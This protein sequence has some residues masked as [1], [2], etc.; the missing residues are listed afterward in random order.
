[1]TDLPLSIRDAADA[2]R[3]GSLKSVDL[4]RAS[5]ER[6]DLVDKELGVYIT[7]M[8]ETAVEAAAKADADFAAGIDRGPLQGIALAVKDIIATDDAPT[9]AQSLVL[10]PTWGDQG[11]APVVARLRAAGAVI[12][13]KTSTMEFANGLPDPEKPF[14]IP[15]NPWNPL[16]WTG[17]SSSGTGNGIAAGVFLGGLGTDTGGSIRIPSSWCGVTGIKATYGRVPKSGC[18]YNGY[19]LDYIGPM[20]RSA[21]DCAALLQVLAGYDASDPTCA[22]VPV[23]DYLAGM[24]GSVA[25]MRLGVEREH[26]TRAE[27]VNPRVAELFED[28][29]AALAG[30][31]AEIVEFSV[32]RYDLYRTAQSVMS[33]TEKFIVHQQDMQTRWTDYGRWTRFSSGAGALLRA[34][35]YVQAQR[36]RTLGYRE[37]SKLVGR[38][39]AVLTP[40]SGVAAPLVDGM[41]TETSAI[42]PNFT[43]LWNFIGLPALSAPM[44]FVDGLPVGLQIVG[45]AWDEATVFRVAD[46]YQQ[47]TDWHRQAPPVPSA[48]AA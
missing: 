19:S 9:T 8:D 27:N 22:D 25:G 28:A 38:F 15:R 7:R 2:L 21:W 48:V 14:P 45:K 11:D 29:V 43:S 37:V 6:A 47:L 17:G 42:R 33:Q 30:A 18:T 12:T 26:H 35:D 3:S 36:V 41:T 46:A 31:G 10:D 5:I 40:T 32:P 13:G 4:A 24:P 34:S 16:H 23:Q 20:A 39:D 1:M 44:G